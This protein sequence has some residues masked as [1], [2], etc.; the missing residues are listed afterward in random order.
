V[1]R[2]FCVQGG[3]LFSRSSVEEPRFRQLRTHYLLADTFQQLRL[4]HRVTAVPLAWQVRFRDL[5]G[6]V[7][8]SFVT[9]A[10]RASVVWQPRQ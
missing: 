7:T 1:C 9:V 6:I 5:P 4:A 8:A 2:L 10:A 3:S